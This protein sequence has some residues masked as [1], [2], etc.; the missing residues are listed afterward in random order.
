[1][2]KTAV[3][4]G[5]LM[6]ISFGFSQTVDSLSLL[7]KTDWHT[8][9]WIEK[10]TVVL[11]AKSKIDTIYEDLTTKQKFLKAKR[12]TYGER[13][14]FES[15]KV[16]YSNNMSCPVGE[17][18]KRINTFVFANNMV[19]IDY[20]TKKWP[21]KNNEW[22]YEKRTFKIIRWSNEAIVLKSL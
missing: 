19:I 20:Q 15:G 16:N 13:I 7:H 3:F 12:N 4:I 11:M 6:T 8:L 9:Q 22:I 14:S 2:K 21:W 5:F 10:D 1:M 17:S 18:L